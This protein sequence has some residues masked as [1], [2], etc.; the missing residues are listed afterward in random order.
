MHRSYYCTELCFGWTWAFQRERQTLGFRAC[1]FILKTFADSSVGD[2]RSPH[3]SC[4]PSIHL[5]GE[6]TL[7]VEPG[8]HMTASDEV[9]GFTSWRLDAG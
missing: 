9:P 7:Y 1:F 5:R 4:V 6:L 3:A 8:G 2:F